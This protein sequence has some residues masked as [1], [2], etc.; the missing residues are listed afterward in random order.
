[1]IVGVL[2]PLPFNDVFD[3]KVEG[4]AVLG[5]MVRVSFGK[6]ILVGV[7]WKLG[8]NSKLDDSKIKPI[9]GR[10][11]FPPLSAEL[12]KF[13]NFVAAYNMAFQGLVL[14]MVLSV[15]GVFDDLKTV[16]LYKLS[17]KTLA[18]AKLKNS[19]ARWRVMDLLRHYPYTRAE[20]AQGAGVGQAVIKTM[21]D[22]GVLE[23]VV[24]QSKRDFGTPRGDFAKV[25]LTDEQQAAADVLYGKVGQG[26]SVTLIDGVTGSGK[27]EVYFEA[28]AKALEDGRQVLIMVP[29]ISLT[30]QWLSRF[31]KRFGVKPACWHSALGTRERI[32]T[33]QGIIE[34]RAKVVVGARSAL[35]LPYADL[36]LIV[37]DESHDHSFKQEDVVN[38]Q[39]RDMAVARAKFEQFPVI[40]STATPDLETLCNVES[41]KYDAVY[42]KSRFAA[43]L[44]P[45]IKIIDLKKD[46][47]QKFANDKAQLSVGWLAPTL[48]NALKENLD[49]GEQSLLFLNRRGYAPLT[50]CRDCGHRIQCPN[51]T[52]WLT[53]HRRS[54]SLVCHHC[55]YTTSIP[56]C[57]PECHSE[58]GLTACGPGVE[59]VAEEVSRRF[60]LARIGVLSS[61]I[62]STLND[63]SEVIRKME[64][65]E[66]DILIG[67]QILAKGHHFPSLTLVGIVD[68]DLG[69]MGSDLRA[70]ETTFQLLSQVAGRAGRGEKKGTVYLQT[71]YPE[72]AVLQALLTDDRERFVSLEKDSRRLLK[73]P[74]F[75]KL[76]A[77]VVSGANQE[78]V[79]K[80]AVY[81]GQ[82]A[83]NTD[84]ITMLGPAPAPIFMLRGKFRYRLLLKTARAIN[85]QE[86]IRTWLK[87]VQVPSSVRVQ[88]DIDPYSFM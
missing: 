65:H 25:K 29:E 17:G 54:K 5:E 69:L 66:I 36:G 79:E 64:D 11:D 8:K 75:G 34:N 77:L 87:R 14:K 19:D 16:T 21:I 80:T 59:R 49:K 37:I 43:A 47:P 58:E 33:W 86:V 76:A 85:I 55:G 73:L 18:E 44:L 62:T 68:A 63:V 46:K 7:V 67:T 39:G 51:C 10:V 22:A 88:V 15:R 70:S 12:M 83:P 28:V 24:V 27:T 82:N 38:Y 6:E 71:L 74:P 81:L 31:E 35:F 72:N 78:A 50:I 41:G 40:L 42:L 52:A 61:D 9:L 32:D 23:P 60:P 45:E 20:I 56:S 3:Y 2:L 53:E 1:M 84:M 26:F 57:C 4:D 13:V 48:V 30:T